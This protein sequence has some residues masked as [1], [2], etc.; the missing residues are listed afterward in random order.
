[1]RSTVATYSGVL[2]DLRRAYAKNACGAERGLKMGAFS[3]NTG[4][5]RCEV[6]D[7]TG[8]VSL[9]VQFLPDV[10]MPCPSCGGVHAMAARRMR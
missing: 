1:M 9:D 4:S 10:D 2:D 5:L 6:C 3:Y 7:G 8:Q